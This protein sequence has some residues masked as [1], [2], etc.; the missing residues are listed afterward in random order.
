MKQEK[1]I[2]NETNSKLIFQS[3]DNTNNNKINCTSAQEINRCLEN[4]W[5]TVKVW[6]RKTILRL[7][8]NNYLKDK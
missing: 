2:C 6:K 1:I 7:K 3:F 8:K 5:G 4:N